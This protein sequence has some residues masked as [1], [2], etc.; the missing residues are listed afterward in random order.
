MP[1]LQAAPDLPIAA[2]RGSAVDARLRPLHDDGPQVA[3]FRLEGGKHRGAIGPAEGDTIARAVRAAVDAGVPIVGM[4][5]TSGADIYEGVASLH[6]WGRIARALSLA[7][8]VVPIVFIVTGPC[9]SGPALLL[10]LADVVVMTPDAFAYVSGPQAVQGFTGITVTHASLGGPHVHDLRSG[11]ASVLAVDEADAIHLVAD[12]LSFLPSNNASVAPIHACE[13]PVDRATRV[14]ADTVPDAPTASY[15]VRKVI[16]DLVDD[17][18]FVELKAHHATNI[19]TALARIGGHPV[20]F[21]ANQTSSLAGTLDI[22][23]SQKAARFVQWCDAFGVA[24]VSLVDTPGFQPGKDIEWRGMIRHGAE[25]VHAFAAARVPR[26]SV[27]LRKAFGGAYIV[28]DS[29]MLGADLCVAWPQ[30]EIA[31]LGAPPAVQILHGKRLATMDEPAAAHERVALEAEYTEQF[32][33]PALASSRGFIDDVIDPLATRFVLAGA[34]EA[35]AHKRET[36]PRR[37]HANTP[38]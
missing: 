27:I 4:M 1:L 7:S 10:G 15:D 28:M 17:G 29:K 18:W 22:E 21:I 3:W 20:G 33:T 38:L 35:L 34:L 16:E 36:T 25:L 24:L 37:R 23:S 26:L 12:V 14:A 9:V 30:A 13:D 32:M 19:V 31:V 8:G 5:S 6:A 2:R 11:V